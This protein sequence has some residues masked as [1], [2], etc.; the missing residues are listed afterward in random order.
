MAKMPMKGKGPQKSAQPGPRTS[1]SKMPG[2]DKPK[3]S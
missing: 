2:L 1:T 3:K